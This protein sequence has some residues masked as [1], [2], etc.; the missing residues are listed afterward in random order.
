MGGVDLVIFDN[1]MALL[2]GDMKDEE[3]WRKTLDWQKSLTRRHIG[4]NL[5]TPY[6]S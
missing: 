6:R 5:D 2:G 4:A 3:S 1:M